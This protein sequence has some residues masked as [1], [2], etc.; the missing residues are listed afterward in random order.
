[1]I[2]I[3]IFRLAITDEWENKREVRF[4]TMKR[5]RAKRKGQAVIEFTFAMII[6]FLMVYGLIKI[7]QWTGKDL[8][9]R[10]RAHEF[11]MYYDGDA[12]S[13]F[14]SSEW[15]INSPARQINPFFYAPEPFD[16]IW[17]GD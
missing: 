5:M 2:R 17:D 11:M 1:M 6:F 14:S 12:G 4:L 3:L 13:W 16:S 10:Q 8:Y 9:H 7:F 15:W